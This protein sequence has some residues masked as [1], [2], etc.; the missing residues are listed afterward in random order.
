MF[1]S[2]LEEFIGRI[3]QQEWQVLENL[4]NGYQFDIISSLL[5][6]ICDTKIVE[7]QSGTTYCTPFQW[8]CIKKA[9]Q[10]V[11]QVMINKGGN[12]MLSKCDQKL[13]SNG[14]QW[15]IANRASSQVIKNIVENYQGQERKHLIAHKNS[16]N[17]NA[18]H[19]AI[20]FHN[21]IEVIRYLI[22]Q[23]GD[24]LL[25]NTN[26]SGCLCLHYACRHHSDPK[27]IDVLY[28]KKNDSMEREDHDKNWPL[29]HAFDGGNTKDIVDHLLSIIPYDTALKYLSKYESAKSM[30]FW[31]NR[32]IFEDKKDLLARPLIREVL[33]ASFI[34]AFYLRIM[35][36]DLYAQILLVAIFSI[37]IDQSVVDGTEAMDRIYFWIMVGA[38]LYRGV[39]EIYQ[40]AKSPLR[41]YLIGE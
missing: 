37:G 24:D 9:P 11:L 25:E 12:E 10:C 41:T 39:R 2:P 1:G 32:Q 14:L 15:A 19:V 4:I 7:T 40:I 22:D 34:R 35:F 30:M 18:I 16:S 13:N 8:A 33:N 29:V 31:I 5:N 6:D 20:R 23:G 3:C 26:S 38:L 28:E 17:E 36:C 27:V 21:E